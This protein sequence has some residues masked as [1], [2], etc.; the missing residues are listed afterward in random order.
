MIHKELVLEYSTEEIIGKFNN[1]ESYYES[2]KILTDSSKEINNRYKFISHILFKNIKNYQNFL[3]VGCG[4][5]K[6]TRFVGKKFKNIVA[7]DSKDEALEQLQP[8]QFFN[9]KILQKIKGSIL[10]MQL[11]KNIKYDFILLSH[12]IYYIPESEIKYLINKLFN[13]LNVNGVILIIFS[14]G[15]N[16]EELVLSFGAQKL[17]IEKLI[18]DSLRDV[19]YISSSL[20]LIQE[21]FISNDF[22]KMSKIASICFNDVNITTTK[23][24]LK[25]YLI[26]NHYNNGY[27]EINM[28]QKFY[29]L[30]NVAQ[31]P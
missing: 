27:Y 20:Y 9:N 18:A 6:L 14:E 7:I 17:S 5:G 1:N 25:N 23:E 30:Y 19:P 8:F 29:L 31:S 26:Y 22:E 4:D 2:L 12:S 10:T 11:P 21:A 24:R 3:D 16:R 13:L 28:Y 15:L